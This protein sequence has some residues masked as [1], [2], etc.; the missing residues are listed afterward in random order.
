[1][2]QGAQTCFPLDD[3]VDELLGEGAEVAGRAE[4]CWHLASSATRASAFRF[5]LFVSGGRVGQGA[6]RK[7]MA[8]K[9]PRSSKLG[10]SHPPRGWAEDGKPGGET[11]V[12]QQTVGVE[13]MEISRIPFHGLLEGPVEKTDIREGERDGRRWARS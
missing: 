11:E 1:M 4:G 7:K 12:V 13:V 10:A 8:D 6:G 5:E 3:P 9:M 2:Y